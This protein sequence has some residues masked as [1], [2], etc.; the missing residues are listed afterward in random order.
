MGVKLNHTI[1]FSCDK[2]VA[3]AFLTEIL[4]LSTATPFGPF[5][6]VE[7]KNEITLD[8][9]DSDREIVPQHYAFLVAE[10]EFD[11]ILARIRQRR[12]PY[13]ADPFHQRAGEI[14]TDSRGRGA[15][16]EDPSGHN[17]EIL[18]KPGW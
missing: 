12:V 16:F 4:G 10:E 6:T 5:L 8:F 14:N 7:L 3:A 2:V 15:Y 18:T 1:V 13:W 17:L 11:I 9:F